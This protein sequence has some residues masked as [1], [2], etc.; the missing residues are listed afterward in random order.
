MKLTRN[1][2]TLMLILALAFSPSQA[3]WD[4]GDGH[5]MHHPQLPNPFGWD[6]DVTRGFVADDWQC[7]QSGPVDD[8]HF[9][10]SAEDDY[11]GN[12]IDFIDLI[13]YSDIPAGQS[14]NPN[15]T[16]S[17]PG[18]KLWSSRIYDFTVRGPKWGVQGWYTPQEPSYH[19]L[20]DHL[21]YFQI[22][23][24]EIKNAFVQEVDTIYWLEIRTTPK[25]VGKNEEQP[26]FG[27]KT[28]LPCW[29][30]NDNAVFKD[31]PNSW[32]ELYGPVLGVPI[33]MAFVITPEPTVLVLL[34]AGVPLLLKRRRS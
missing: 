10:L 26:Y 7:S 16:W 22:N 19:K 5:K 12:G 9:W 11:L 27:W 13:I 32:Q 15:V 17:H 24:E 23:I 8:I 18:D 2:A 4:P 3:D 30:W 34:L 6:V 29:G 28:T 33:D 14:P 21:K 25:A 20:F 31:A 1:L